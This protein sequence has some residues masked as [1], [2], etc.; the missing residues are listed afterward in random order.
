MRNIVIILDPAHGVNIAGK[1][2][3]D[4]RHLEYKWSRDRVFSL[5][6]KLSS[7]GYTVH[8]TTRGDKEPG[9]TKRA[10]FATNA[11]GKNKLLLSL[12][13]N[14]SGDGSCWKSARGFEVWTSKGVT[15]S[16]I[17]GD[18]IFGRL[19]KDFPSMC[20]RLNIDKY[21]E[22][23]KESNFTV[24]MGAGYMAVLIEWLFQ[25]NKEDVEELCNAET[26]DRFEDSLVSAIEEINSYFNG[27]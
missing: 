4:S 23:D 24:L 16:D 26:N 6:K 20:G 18:I 21:L 13:N 12:H 15:D 10:K 5:E 3:P 8:V 11:N 2:S 27:I 1:R 22:R 25:D 17:C 9:L 7:L 14:A 19:K